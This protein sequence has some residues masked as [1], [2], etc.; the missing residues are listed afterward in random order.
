MAV[1]SHVLPSLSTKIPT[2]SS[3]P[4]TLTLSFSFSSPKLF[5]SVEPLSLFSASSSYP[6]PL[7]RKSR[8][9]DSGIVRN[10]S[11]SSEIEPEEEVASGGEVADF[12]PDLK[13]F[14]G[15]LPFS[16]DSAQLAGL[17]QGAGN[18]EMVEVCSLDLSG[19]LDFFFF[20]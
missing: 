11:V 16:V 12:S 13:L 10:V 14:V 20:F 17:F 15:N 19:V 6:S 7:L 3:K 18:V 5:R 4:K 8:T 9:F 2:I 1:S